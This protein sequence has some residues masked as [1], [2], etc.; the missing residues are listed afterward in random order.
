MP[1]RNKEAP[2]RGDKYCWKLHVPALYAALV[3]QRLIGV[4]MP[5]VGNP[6]QCNLTP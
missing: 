1:L 6:R 5:L 3:R 2:L 4:K